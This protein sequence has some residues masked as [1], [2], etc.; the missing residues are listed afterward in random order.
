[1]GQDE[2]LID[3]LTWTQ[4]EQRRWLTGLSAAEQEAA[5]Q[6]DAWAARDLVAH[7]AEWDEVMRQILI[8]AVEGREPPALPDDDEINAV[9][10]ERN[11]GLSWAEVADKANNASEGLLAQVRAMPAEVLAA[12]S[13]S[14]GRPLRLAMMFANIDHKLRHMGENLIARG[15]RD[16]AEAL[17][18]EGTRRMALMDDSPRYRGTLHYNLAC[19]YA[20]HGRREGA[21]DT[22]R[23][24]LALRPDLA[25]YA[26][27]DADFVSSRDD[28]NFRALV[29]KN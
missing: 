9:F 29:S 10:F 21:L 7:F 24:A 16:A 6:P 8:A 12:P 14:G 15:E 1:M 22:L 18:V 13:R 20:L 23:E 26:G 27:Q 25:E 3:V 4:E 19:A 11:R 5:G 28:P 2:Q 17:M